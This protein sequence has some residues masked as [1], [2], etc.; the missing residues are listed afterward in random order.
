MPL[1]G[2][3]APMSAK[4]TFWAWDIEIK[5]Y[6]LKAPAKY[7]LAALA[8]CHNDKTGRCDPSAQ[9]L[10]DQTG[11]DIKTVRAAVQDLQAVHLIS[12][13]KR[14]GKSP[15]YRLH[16]DHESYPHPTQKRAYPKTGTPKNGYTQKRVHTL[17]KNGY[18]PYPKTG[19][20]HI[21]N[22]K[23]NLINSKLTSFSELINL[24]TVDNFSG[25]DFSIRSPSGNYHFQQ[26][27]T[28]YVISPG[29]I[30]AIAVLYPELAD[31]E[32]AIAELCLYAKERNGNHYTSDP[33]QTI[34]NWLEK[35]IQ[36][37][38]GS[39]GQPSWLTE[40]QQ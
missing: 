40:R 39:P 26:G 11:L 23:G 35:R 29:D 3:R 31:P 7:V 15:H 36:L 25:E 10:A 37:Q 17:P 4:A 30:A 21:T 5:S 34:Q 27:D 12:I 20:E 24:V 13:L 8:H 18:T 28:V 14:A 16:F 9:Y 38:A 32:E 1:Q 22:L 2:E 6:G 19:T 33:V